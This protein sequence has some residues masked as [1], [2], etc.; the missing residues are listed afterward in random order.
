MNTL[1]AIA[2]LLMFGGITDELRAGVILQFEPP[3]NFLGNNGIEEDGFIFSAPKAPQFVNGGGLSL[4]N[5]SPGLGNLNGLNT[6]PYDGSYYAVPFSGSEPVLRQADG[7]PF[8]LKS[9]DLA[10]YSA[11]FSDPNT[12]AVTGYYA[13]GGT[14][15]RQLV[16]N[17]SVAGLASDF[18]TFVFDAQ[19]SDLNRVVMFASVPWANGVGFSI[20]NIAVWA[21]P[22]P[23]LLLLVGL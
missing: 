11:T 4:R 19:W 18:Q 14:I 3:Q 20:D 17:G 5:P 12:F 1:A 8:Q 21:I 6:V 2:V 9:M 16:W 23:G 7:L 15:A 10:P 13:S 22:V